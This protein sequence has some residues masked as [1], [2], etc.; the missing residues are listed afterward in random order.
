L[1]SSG[2]IFQG[3]FKPLPA[4]DRDGDGIFGSADLCPLQN[5]TGY[6][7]NLDGCIDDTDGDSIKDNVDLCPTVAAVLGYDL[8]SDGCTDDTD[9]D[10]ITDD[11]DACP[12][13]DATG[14]DAD[15]DGCI[16]TGISPPIGTITVASSADPVLDGVAIAGD[17]SSSD[18]L[19][20]ARYKVY[21]SDEAFTVTEMQFENDSDDTNSY[22]DDDAINTVILAYPTSLD[23]PTVLDGRASTVLIAGKASFTGLDMAVPESM[24][25]DEN[26]I[27]VEVYVTTNEITTGGAFSSGAQIEMDFD[28]SD[29]FHAI[30]LTSGTTV[31]E[32]SSYFGTTADV[33]ANEIALYRALPS[34]A[35]DDSSTSPCSGTLIESSTTNVYCFGVTATGGDVALRSISFTAVPNLLST[36]SS[37]GQLAYPN[38]WSITEYDSSGLIGSSLGTGT[39]VSIRTEAKIGFFSS[40]VV[41]AEGTTNYYV[42][43]APISFTTS[44]DT[45]SLA[46]YIKAGDTSYQPS[47]WSYLG[48]YGIYALAWSDD[49]DLF[50]SPGGLWT[51]SYKL[52]GLPTTTFMSR[53]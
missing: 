22:E 32:S 52:D 8:D 51:N 15:S 10:T 40:L 17:D 43:Q 23:A 16:D 26:A 34:F 33:D 30:G 2:T 21:A 6:D 53:E 13:E 35:I 1:Y 20:V 50:T 41:I 11:L 7:L 14:H 12:T 42:L 27:E 45:S 25:G 47:S 5:A 36:G 37:A 49:A 24:S 38:G 3:A 46:V 31:T 48:Y 4:S 18:P 19:L 28:A 44:S 39:W 29:E 9:G